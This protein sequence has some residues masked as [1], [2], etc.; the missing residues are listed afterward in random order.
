[1]AFWVFFCGRVR[2]VLFNS[3]FYERSASDWLESTPPHNFDPLVIKHCWRELLLV[4]KELTL[5]VSPC[6]KGKQCRNNGS[7]KVPNVPPPLITIVMGVGLGRAHIINIKFKC[8]RTTVPV[9]QAYPVARVA[10]G[11]CTNRELFATPSLIQ[12]QC[13]KLLVLLHQYAWHGRGWRA[14]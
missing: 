5:C 10:P 9:G 14:G 3:V 2:S 11:L 6:V 4:L 12:K 8:W 1:M 13:E 7:D